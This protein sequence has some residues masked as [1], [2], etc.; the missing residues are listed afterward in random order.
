MANYDKY[1]ARHEKT[2]GQYELK[3]YWTSSQTVEFENGQTLEEY[4]TDLL[5]DID[6][7]GDN[8]DYSL[9]EGK[10][11]LYSGNTLVGSTDMAITTRPNFILDDISNLSIRLSNGIIRFTWTDPDDVVFSELPLISW[12]GTKVVRK[13]GSAPDDVTDGGIQTELMANAP[14]SVQGFYE[15]P[16]MVE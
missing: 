12:D 3:S 14:E 2:D 1:Y 9:D 8:L 16:R 5:S 15:V 6:G 4:K 10:V 11:Y 13:V 7:K